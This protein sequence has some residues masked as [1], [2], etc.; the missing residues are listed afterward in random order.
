MNTINE[1]AMI[2]G[3]GRISREPFHF[4][5]GDSIWTAQMRAKAVSEACMELRL[6]GGKSLVHHAVEGVEWNPMI[7]MAE[8]LGMEILV[9]I[10]TSKKRM[11]EILCCIG[12]STNKTMLSF[13]LFVSRLEMNALKALNEQTQKE[14][15]GVLVGEW[16]PVPHMREAFK[17]TLY[18]YM[19]A[20]RNENEKTIKKDNGKKRRRKA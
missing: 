2:R 17:E 1:H 12:S 7:F 4:T 3:S 15:K 6:V 19:D 14:Y 18:F 13:M 11:F 9:E 16:H 5:A 10:P 8:A 20:K